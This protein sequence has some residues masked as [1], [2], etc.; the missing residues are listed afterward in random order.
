MKKVQSILG[1]AAVAATTVSMFAGCV[2]LDPKPDPTRYFVMAGADDLTAASSGPCSGTLLVGPVRV[3]GY[4]DQP[5][6]VERRGAHEII[7]L[8]L[9]RWVEPLG[10]TLPRLI[11]SRL[12]NELPDRCVAGYQRKTPAAGAQQLEL[13]VQRFELTDGNEAVVAIRWRVFVV[14]PDGSDRIGSAT[15]TQKFEATGDRVG[16]GIGALSKG[17]DDVVHQ[18]A[19]SLTNR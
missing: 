9:H 1:R 13:E 3:A 7:P 15:S 16:A 6:V 18:L 19:G 5:S 8:T 11:T 17:L 10:E 12:A 2:S 14:G 4:A